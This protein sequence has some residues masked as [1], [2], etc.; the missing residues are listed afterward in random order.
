MPDAALQPMTPLTDAQARAMITSMAP[1][2]GIPVEPDWHD[3]I[4]Q[5][6][7]TNARIAQLVADFPLDDEVEPASVYSPKAQP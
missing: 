6:L 5:N 3:P 1:M 2:L 7:V 4:V